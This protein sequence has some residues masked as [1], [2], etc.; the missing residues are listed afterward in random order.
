MHVG[1]VHRCVVALLGGITRR[2]WGF[3]AHLMPPLVEQL[4]PVR[5]LSWFAWNLPR[6]QRTLA[7]FGPV[8]THL[9]AT[10]ISLLND[11]EYGSQGHGYA[12]QLAYLRDH[13]ELFPLDQHQLGELCGRPPA[14]VRH[15]LLDAA[16]RAGLHSDAPWLDRAI[17]LATTPDPRPVERN[18]LRVAHLVRMFSL[19]NAAATADNTALDEAHDP[20]NKDSALKCRYHAMRSAANTTKG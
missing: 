5:A 19:L 9:L 6:Y 18:E 4:G 17:E 3:A 8:R 1:P 12:L 15:R 2:H 11:C 14:L 7:R 13:G 20:V 16:Q 10:A